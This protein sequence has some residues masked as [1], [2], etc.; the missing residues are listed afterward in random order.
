MAFRS[1]PH[2]QAGQALKLL[3]PDAVKGVV[4]LRKQVHANRIGGIYR[5]EPNLQET[6]AAHIRGTKYVRRT[7]VP[8]PQLPRHGLCG[9]QHLEVIARAFPQA[10]HITVAEDPSLAAGG[11]GRCCT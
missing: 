5:F 4:A 10:Q 8:L 6:R 7:K 2:C 11:R 1:T 3:K 9:G